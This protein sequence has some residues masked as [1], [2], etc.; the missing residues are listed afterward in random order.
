M[1][2][3][4]SNGDR[5]WER[6]FPAVRLLEAARIAIVPVSLVIAT[7]AAVALWCLNRFLDRVFPA[8]HL[9]T[10]TNLFTDFGHLTSG[11]LANPPWPLM[12][13]VARPWIS[14]VRPVVSLL[15][16]VPS[17]GGWGHGLA[18][19]F[20]AVGLWSVAGTILCR[21]SALLIARGDESSLPR[22]ARYSLRRWTASAMGPLI[23]LFSAAILAFLLAGFGLLG[24]L[25]Y[26]GWLWLVMTSPVIL[27]LAFATAFLLIT[28]AFAWP[29]MVAS[30]A[31]DDCDS[32]GALSR[33][34][35]SLT[36]RPWQAFGFACGGL[37]TGFL[38]M[39]LVYLFSLVTFW[40]ATSSAAL[41]GGVEPVQVSLATP[42]AI[43]TQFV[44]EGVG[45]SYFWAASTMV[46]LLLRQEIDGMPLS[47]LA[48]DDELRPVREDLPVVGIPATD[49]PVESTAAS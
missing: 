2:D 30:V 24:R 29:L 49:L 32:F 20:A 14:V 37:V 11:D 17:W 33:A 31:T 6:L 39:A 26:L 47:R 16:S 41:G 35:S 23:P 42:I 13:L 9:G 4:V 25:P 28:T 45:I 7:A 44:M 34:Y 22:A 38:L 21:R 36:G 27:V 48:L 18:H 1:Q 10:A 3:D 40:C 8:N 43:L 15:V 46:W 12:D 5:S 19:L